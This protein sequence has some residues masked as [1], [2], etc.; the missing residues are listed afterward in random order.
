M[1]VNKAVSGGGPGIS[2][3]LTFSD[4]LM[5]QKLLGHNKVAQASPP[6]SCLGAASSHAYRIKLQHE[7]RSR[8][9]RLKT[10]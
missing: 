9:C 3:Q 7:E 10:I 6:F 4:F 1:K 5:H 2:R 8:E